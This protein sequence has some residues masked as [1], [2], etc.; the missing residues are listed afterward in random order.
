[1]DNDRFSRRKRYTLNM[2][3]EIFTRGNVSLVAKGVLATLFA[4]DIEDMD[5]NDELSENDGVVEL[6]QKVCCEPKDEI[7]KALFEL[8]LLGYIEW[9]VDNPSFS[10]FYDTSEI[11]EVYDSYTKDALD[12][13]IIKEMQR[14]LGRK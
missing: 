6:L 5:W 4:L 12:A 1:M 11:K 9:Y 10:V 7:L 13:E 2:D 8:D 3:N 14:K